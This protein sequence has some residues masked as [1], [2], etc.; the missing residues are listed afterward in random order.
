[1]GLESF[2]T[3]SNG[4]KIANPRFF[5]M[6]ERE[7]ERVQR[8]LSKTGKGDVEWRKRV[9]IVQRVYERIANK[10]YDFVHKLSRSLVNEYGFIAFEDLN[11]NGMVRNHCLAKSIGDAAW[12]MLIAT[13]KYKA[14]SA[15]TIIAMVN[16]ANTL[17]ICSRCGLIVEKEPKDRAHECHGCGLVID[18]DENAAVNILRLGLQ[19]IGPRAVKAHRV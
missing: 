17:R 9:R 7:L 8:R 1:M 19:S 6:G 3:L 18:R 12:N 2:A 13:T 4:M 11:I 14:E 5:C 16:P 10:R 15:G